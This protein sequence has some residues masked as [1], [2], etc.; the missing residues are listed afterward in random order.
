MN[1]IA[2]LE[3]AAL[4]A[5]AALARAD[6]LEAEALA[7]VAGEAFR[8]LAAAYRAEGQPEPAEVCDTTAA[9]AVT[10]AAQLAANPRI[11]QARRMHAAL[12]S[13]PR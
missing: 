3:S 6:L 2:A 8:A 9:G 11:S 12:S 10:L 13:L 5:S 4:D 1:T 7:L